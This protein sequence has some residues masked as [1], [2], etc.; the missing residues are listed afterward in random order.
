[1]AITIGVFENPHD[2]AV[3]MLK[4]RN[5]G[6]LE[7]NMALLVL[8]KHTEKGRQVVHVSGY[9]EHDAHMGEIRTVEEGA[10]LA[11]SR[12]G[13]YT[14]D[15]IA[16]LRDLHPGSGVL[17]VRSRPDQAPWISEVLRRVGARIAVDS[18]SQSEL[19]H[20]ASEH[21]WQ[22]ASRERI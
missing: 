19:V 9:L 20:F 18:E 16:W 13:V 12:E 2:V 5:L 21:R 11:L 6:I 3:A 22:G 1:M 10:Y 14:E 17:I 7:Y 4:I 8:E 15:M